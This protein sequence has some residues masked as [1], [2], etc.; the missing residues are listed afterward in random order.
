MD[1]LKPS[2]KVSFP[3]SSEEIFDPSIHPKQH[4]CQG[5][6]G[7]LHDQW[8][9][10]SQLI[11]SSNEPLPN[12]GAAADSL[13]CRLG[14]CV[15][16][17]PGRHAWGMHGNLVRLLQPHLV[18]R[19]RAREDNTGQKKPHTE[20]RI[21]LDTARLCLKFE[22]HEAVVMPSSAC[23]SGWGRVAYG[24]LQDG[25]TGT[26]PRVRWAMVGH[27]NHASQSGYMFTVIPVEPVHVTHADRMASLRVPNPVRVQRSLEF[28]RDHLPAEM[29]WTMRIY[30]LESSIE[31]YFGPGKPPDGLFVTPYLDVD[32]LVFWRGQLEE[33]ES[34]RLQQ[35]ARASR[36]RAQRPAPRPP[37]RVRG[38]AAEPLGDASESEDELAGAQPDGG[39]TDME[40]E[41][42]ADSVAA[43]AELFADMEEGDATV[44]VRPAAG[45]EP[46]AAA[47]RAAA[48]APSPAPADAAEAPEPPPAPAAPVARRA[49]A[50]RE[51]PF[52]DTNRV[53][54]G[55]GAGFLVYYAAGDVIQAHCRVPGHGDCR[56]QR[57]V[58][59][60]RRR[61]QGRPLGHLAAWLLA[62][63]QFANQAAHQ[64]RTFV[65]SLEKRQEAREL[66][67]VAE[68]AD[69]LFKQENDEESGWEREPSEVV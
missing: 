66:L 24:A 14:A 35:E 2:S 61:G 36:R 12:A 25:A 62:G 65:P 43:A 11:R 21:L 20:C 57:T 28:L 60:G 58:T 7:D 38:R 47:A 3:V 39:E 42:D 53:D 15:C 46:A 10:Q 50:G 48:P 17:G 4:P 54:F 30:R 19:K 9:T 68:G 37:R 33:E 45:G 23:A 51:G 56:R 6:L 8:E 16:T 55:E 49:R 13:C 5:L 64:A 41:E 31:G 59:S 27:M 18:S 52:G 69:E 26:T 40:E 34:R 44:A 67:A 29:G 22:Q 1:D 63:D 32:P